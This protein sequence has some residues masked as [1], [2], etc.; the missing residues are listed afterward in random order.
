M[1]KATELRALAD[2]FWRAAGLE[3]DAK[4]SHQL[5]MTAMHLHTA[6]LLIEAGITPEELPSGR[7]APR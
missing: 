1:T 6:A 7:I 4:T 3:P 2:E 5:L